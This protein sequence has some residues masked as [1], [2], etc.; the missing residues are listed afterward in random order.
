MI[1]EPWEPCPPKERLQAYASGKL[2]GKFNE[3]TYQHLKFC[4]KCLQYLADLKKVPTPED[5]ITS[6][7][8]LTR[9]WQ[10]FRRLFRMN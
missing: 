10:R 8:L 3:W 2:E 7:G 9:F 4:S 5:I 6:G 1:Q